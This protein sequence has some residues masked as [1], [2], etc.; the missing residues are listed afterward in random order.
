L[1]ERQDHQPAKVV[2]GYLLAA[3]S[4]FGFASGGLIGKWLMTE[5]SAE[6]G[7]WLLPPLGIYISPEILSA[8]RV[9]IAAVAMLV[10]LLIKSPRELK[11]SPKSLGFFAI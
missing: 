9:L 6:T 10:V 5:P 8:D 3:L 11:A 2:L 1:N 4:A 7:D